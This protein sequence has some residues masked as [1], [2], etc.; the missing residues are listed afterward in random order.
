MFGEEDAWPTC[1]KLFVSL[2]AQVCPVYALALDTA[3][4]MVLW[5]LGS[6]SD[7]SLRPLA[8]FACALPKSGSVL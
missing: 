4:A 1:G 8:P 2:C 6:G 5:P 7:G 3:H